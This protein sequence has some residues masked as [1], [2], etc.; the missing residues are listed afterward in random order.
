MQE[1]KVDLPKISKKE[2]LEAISKGVER[3]FPEELKVL[4]DGGNPAHTV[5]EAIQAGVEYSFPNHHVIYDAIRDG[6]SKSVNVSTD[7]VA[8]ILRGELGM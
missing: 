6:I 3:A 8:D 1:L 7:D 4:V 5:L 2:L